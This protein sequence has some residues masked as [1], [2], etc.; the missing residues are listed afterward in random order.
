MKQLKLSI[1]PKQEPTEGQCLNSSGYSIKING[2]ELG[3]GVTDFKLEMSADK[4]PK[5]TI[6]AIPDVIEIDATV[7]AEIQK[8][9]SEETSNYKDDEQQ[10]VILEDLLIY[11]KVL[12]NSDFH[13][14]IIISADGVYLEQT[15][16]FHPLDETLLD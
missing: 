13:A 9:Q 12:K 4:K 1:K 6:T 8:L 11:S 10:K 2:W 16:E 7:I 5:I 3:R 15:K 14:K